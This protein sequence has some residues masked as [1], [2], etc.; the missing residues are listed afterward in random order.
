MKSE[1]AEVGGAGA[2]G[3]PQTG[4]V[5]GDDALHIDPEPVGEHLDERLNVVLQL[6]NRRRSGGRTND[7]DKLRP[8]LHVDQSVTC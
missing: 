4:V 6:P 8:T 5:G 3:S 7:V 1:G 2:H